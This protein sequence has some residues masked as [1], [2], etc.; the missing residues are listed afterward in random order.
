MRLRFK[1][2]DGRPGITRLRPAVRFTALA[3]LI[4]PGAT[5]YA[6][7]PFQAFGADP[8]E[9]ELGI[10][11]GVAPAADDIEI[12]D[13]QPGFMLPLANEDV[14]K[15]LLQFDAFIE[16]K[17]W[18]KAFRLLSEINDQELGSMVPTSE[19]TT[20]PTLR[21]R[22]QQV[23][24]SLPSD[25]LRAFR[26]YFD[27]QAREQFDQARNHPM[28]GSDAQVFA[29]QRLIDRFLASSIGG[30]IAALAGDLY[31]ERGEFT[32]A[33]I[34]WGLAIEHGSA[35]TK[36]VFAL[37]IKRVLAM[38]RAGKHTAAA[39]LFAGLKARYSASSL[40]LGG[41][42]VDPL[43]MLR[44][45]LQNSG[46][47]PD[48]INV[49]IRGKLT[50]PNQEERP[51][52]HLEFLDQAT[53]LNTNNGSDRGYYRSPDDLRRFVP[54]VVADQD[55]VYFAWLEVVFALDRVTGKIVWT[56]GSL[57]KIYKTTGQRGNGNAGDP[58]NYRI[59]HGGDT[60]LVTRAINAE[61]RRN[62]KHS[63]VAYGK[64]T[65]E[66][67]WSS[68][69]HI[70]WPLIPDAGNQG[71]PS[72]AQVTV[73]G[74]AHVVDGQVGYAVITRTDTTDCYLRRFDPKTGEVFWT[75]PLGSADPV[76]FGYSRIRRM[77]QPT[78]SFSDGMLYVLMSNGALLAVNTSAGQLAWALKM[79]V[80]YDLSLAADQRNTSRLYN[81]LR[82]SNNPNGSGA[83]FIH[84][85]TLYA[86]QHLGD[87]LFAVDPL[88]GEV[89]SSLGGLPHDA[90][91]FGVD[92][93][94]A[95]FAGAKISAYRLDGDMG[96]VWE[97]APQVGNPSDLKP[98]V[99][100]Q[101][102]LMMGAGEL[103]LGSK[104]D[105]ERVKSFK[106]D[107]LLGPLGGHVYRFD[108]LLVCIGPRSITAF[109]LAGPVG[110]VGDQ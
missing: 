97:R 94:R 59:A 56:D 73:L 45:T 107:R 43:A 83:M 69:E 74:Q 78:M 13:Y 38:Y 61:D 21:V 35:G 98:L 93:E 27:A 54:G 48:A 12:P 37:Q 23:L 40:E 65:G 10:E 6:D 105:G 1:W 75:I 50:I 17:D 30:Q 3:A 36:E 80:P 99:G 104:K 87:T 11:L 4:L 66:V 57:K 90:R 106:S 5:A 96:Q 100:D 39:E 9:Q 72:A 51:L 60:L 67:L 71:K 28:P 8:F 24:L 55:R 14:S 44:Q 63:L 103:G 52:W 42:T 84:R 7:E 77:P 85:G 64:Q 95:Y 16:G 58:R 41:Q 15:Q 68:E 88:S 20:Y 19:G 102:V 46:E 29:L 33:E 31:F 18:G 70:D 92:D 47:M 89:R 22:L 49:P 62:A 86:K 79:G 25:G 110:P 26:L 82:N 108:D 76:S 53:R 2:C 91:L 109:S 81:A 32:K 34:N 101:H